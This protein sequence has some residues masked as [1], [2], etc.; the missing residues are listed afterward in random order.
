M[1][2]GLTNI[3]E[4]SQHYQMTVVVAAAAMTE[5]TSGGGSRR[6]AAVAAAA[7]LSLALAN[8]RYLP[9]YLPP[10]HLP[11]TEYLPR[12]PHCAHFSTQV[13]RHLQHKF[14][15]CSNAT[16]FIHLS[17]NDHTAL[18]TAVVTVIVK[19]VATLAVSSAAAGRLALDPS[20]SVALPTRRSPALCAHLNIVN[21]TLDTAIPGR[22][23]E[24]CH[25]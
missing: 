7:A 15:S 4:M 21:A 1:G 10:T 20:A 9:T 8:Y 12:P 22:K 5:T 18:A 17:I 25:N 2:G 6:T 16:D 3:S 19:V 24:G 11:P 14:E 13:Q 23:L